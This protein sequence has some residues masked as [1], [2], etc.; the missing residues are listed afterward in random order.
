MRVF[1]SSQHSAH[2]P[3]IFPGTATSLTSSS[4]A[5]RTPSICRSHSIFSTH[6]GSTA[7]KVSGPSPQRKRGPIAGLVA[8]KSNLLRRLKQGLAAGFGDWQAARSV[9]DKQS[10]TTGGSCA[11]TQVSRRRSWN[12]S[13][14]SMSSDVSVTISQGCSHPTHAMSLDTG[15]GCLGCWWHTLL[16]LRPAIV[17]VLRH[18]HTGVNR[19]CAFCS[20][21]VW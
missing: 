17:T 1:S 9:S 20:R 10:I 12:G 8:V 3:L 13:R 6:D 7:A 2:L 21:N 5:T 18:T 15:F 14:N 4:T 19:S 11:D 16:T